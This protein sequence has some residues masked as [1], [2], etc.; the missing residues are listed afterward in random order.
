MYGY[1]SARWTP[2]L[3]YGIVPIDRKH[4][5]DFQKQPAV[6]IREIHVKFWS[7]SALFLCVCNFCSFCKVLLPWNKPIFSYTWS[8]RPTAHHTGI[9]ICLYFLNVSYE[10]H[11]KIHRSNCPLTAFVKLNNSPCFTFKFS[12]SLIFFRR[13]FSLQLVLQYRGTYIYNHSLYT[14]FTRDLTYQSASLI[15]KFW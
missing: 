7:S 8:T 12:Y 15:S 13:N 2:H 14:S 6:C 11:F 9:M 3:E 4:L 10:I 5:N 1:W